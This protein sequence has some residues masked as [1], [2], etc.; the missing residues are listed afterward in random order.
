MLTWLSYDIK[1]L[2]LVCRAFDFFICTNPISPIYVAAC[3]FFYTVNLKD[4]I[5]KSRFNNE[6]SNRTCIFYKSCNPKS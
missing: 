3:V 5:E 6:N 4:N 2:E 1:E